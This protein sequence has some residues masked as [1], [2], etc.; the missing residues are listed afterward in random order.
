MLFARLWQTMG[1]RLSTWRQRWWPLDPVSATRARADRLAAQI[2]ERRA[3]LGEMR[4]LLDEM[5]RDA[6]TTQK[7][8]DRLTAQVAECVKAGYE[9]QAW[10][11]ALDLEELHR[12]LADVQTEVRRHEQVCWSYEFQLRQM[13]RQLDEVRGQL[14]RLGPS[15]LR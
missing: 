3:A 10:P 1:G 6:E 11:L 9:A 5:R 4:D 2:E 12:R 13:Q 15:R 7:Q 14:R 8:A